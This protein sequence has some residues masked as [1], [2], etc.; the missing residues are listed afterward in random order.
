MSI[1]YARVSTQDQDLTL[2]YDAR[3]KSEL[4]TYRRIGKSA[5]TNNPDRQTNPAAGLV[6]PGCFM[7]P[8]P[9]GAGAANRAGCRP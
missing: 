5:A 3:K 1:G 7:A 6:G 4:S 9:W 8:A 2:Q